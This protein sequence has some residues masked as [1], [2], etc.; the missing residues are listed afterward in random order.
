MDKIYMKYVANLFGLELGEPFTLVNSDGD[1]VKNWYIF[2][3]NGLE[4]SDKFDGIYEITGGCDVTLG[5]MLRGYYDIKKIPWKPASGQDYYF[6]NTESGMAYATAATWGDTF[7]DL[8]RYKT[9][10]VCKTANE[11]VEKAE[12]MLEALKED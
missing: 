11:A 3:E 5:N 9:S 6:P 10:M 2:T 7:N 12:K 4:K 1:E 8:E